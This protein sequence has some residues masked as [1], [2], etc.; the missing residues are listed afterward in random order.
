M[1]ESEG[2]GVEEGMG[3]WESGWEGGRKEGEK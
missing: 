2:G 3:G 1:R